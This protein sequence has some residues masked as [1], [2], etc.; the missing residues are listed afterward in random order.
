MTTITGTVRNG[1]IVPS[2]PFDWPDGSEVEITRRPAANEHP[3][4]EGEQASSPEAIEEWLAAL[5]A[6]PTPAMTDQE[7]A[8]WE[9]RRREDKE[10]ELAQ[11]GVRE[12]KL[13]QDLE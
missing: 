12:A 6:I 4:P 5:D 3:A 11:A 7:W 8:A 2:E 1:L 10:W 13:R 9:Q